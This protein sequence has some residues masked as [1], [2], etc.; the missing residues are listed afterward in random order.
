[1]AAKMVRRNGGVRLEEEGDGDIYCTI[2]TVGPWLGPSTTP[3]YYRACYE[4]SLCS[5]DGCS[6]AKSW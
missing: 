1:M 3:T 2:F 4:N 6:A 5:S